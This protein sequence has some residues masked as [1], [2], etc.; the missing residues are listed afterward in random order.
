MR[1]QFLRG[2]SGGACSQDEAERLAGGSWGMDHVISG[3]PHVHVA[4]QS[5]ANL[6][7]VSIADVVKP[8]QRLCLT[9]FLVAYGWSSDRTI[10]ALRVCP[11]SLGRIA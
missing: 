3:S 8:G 5:L 1:R 10:P 4:S 9:K 6:A 11:E 2:R 7:R